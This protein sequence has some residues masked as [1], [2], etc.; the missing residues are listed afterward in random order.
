MVV[1]RIA[2]NYPTGED[3]PNIINSLEVVVERI[4][5]II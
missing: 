5:L 2:T 4:T 3:S 1:A